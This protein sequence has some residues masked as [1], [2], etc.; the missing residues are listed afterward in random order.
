MLVPRLAPHAPLETP[1]HPSAREPQHRAPR[2]PTPSRGPAH[3]TRA[4][5]DLSAPTRPPRRRVLA[6]PTVSTGMTPAPPVLLVINR[7]T[8]RLK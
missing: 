3:A 7:S 1:A 8:E 2:G 5:G 4:R 6:G